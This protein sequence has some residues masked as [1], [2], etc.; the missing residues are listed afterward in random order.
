MATTFVAPETAPLHIQIRSRTRPP[1]QSILASIQTFCSDDQ[2]AVASGRSNTTRVSHLLPSTV[3][4]LSQ[5]SS[6][7]EWAETAKINDA[8][9]YQVETTVETLATSSVSKKEK[10]SKKAGSKWA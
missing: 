8:P 7:V 6:A 4:Q 3:F 9:F 1:L 5:F 10:K 2:M